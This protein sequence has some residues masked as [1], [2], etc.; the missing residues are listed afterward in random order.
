MFENIFAIDTL[1]AQTGNYPGKPA[2]RDTQTD[3]D[4][5]TR[6]G[7]HYSLYKAELLKGEC[8]IFQC[9]DC[10]RVIL[11]W[12]QTAKQRLIVAGSVH[13]QDNIDR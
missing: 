8:V 12:W 10:A 11:P 13:G 5:C 1:P 7:A 6:C 3:P 9:N 4:I 2:S